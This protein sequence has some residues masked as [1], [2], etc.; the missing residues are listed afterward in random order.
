LRTREALKIIIGRYRR[1][2]PVHDLYHLALARILSVF[3]S[4]TKA[5]QLGL[6]GI[7]QSA[8]FSRS[9][10]LTGP[11]RPPKCSLLY[12]LIRFGEDGTSIAELET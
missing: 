3:G 11:R 5:F 4:L 1:H 8:G 10:R 2:T 12:M 6:R 9:L 7:S